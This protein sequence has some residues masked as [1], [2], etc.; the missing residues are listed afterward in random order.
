MIVRLHLNLAVQYFIIDNEGAEYTKNFTEF[1]I[2]LINCFLF[3][4][5]M[6]LSLLNIQLFPLLIYK[7]NFSSQMTHKR[8]F[9]TWLLYF[10]LLTWQNSRFDMKGH[11]CEINQFLYP[12]CTISGQELI[13]ITLPSYIYKVL[14]YIW[15]GRNNACSLHFF[16]F[17]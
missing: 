1:R 11:L 15:Q 7:Q 13:L 10:N 5:L 14:Y 4:I 17:H 6:L 2:N 12:N 16:S 9:L 3:S 8:N